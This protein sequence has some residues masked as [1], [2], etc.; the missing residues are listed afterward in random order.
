MRLLR[1]LVPNCT[2]FFRWLNKTLN[3]ATLSGEAKGSDVHRITEQ[4]GPARAHG[5]WGRYLQ[6]RRLR[7]YSLVPLCSE[8]F[9]KPYRLAG[10]SVAP[11][12]SVNGGCD[13]SVTVGP[14]I[15]VGTEGKMSWEKG[16]A[17]QSWSS[18]AMGWERVPDFE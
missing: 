18:V 8:A 14:E 10:A 4:V 12:F 15:D 17:G 6:R 11:K 7:P 2:E 9:R 1:S 3:F 16:K 5:G 13:Q